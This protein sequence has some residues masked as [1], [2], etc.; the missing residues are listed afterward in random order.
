MGIAKR[1][2]REAHSDIRKNLLNE[3]VATLRRA[4]DLESETIGL[5][6]PVAAGT[7]IQI[8]KYHYEMREYDSAVL[9]IRQAITIYRNAL[10]GNHPQVGKSTLLLASIFDRHGLHISPQGT[11]KDDSELELYVDALEPL[12]AT[13]GEVH[14]EIG[15]LYAKIGYLYGKKGDLS[16]SLLAYKASLKSHGEPSSNKDNLEVMSIWVRITENLTGLKLWDEVLVAGRRALYLLRC[17]RNALFAMGSAS[18]SSSANTTSQ[19]RG[20]TTKKSQIRITSD[21]YYTSLFSTLQSLGHAHTSLSNYALAR[22]ACSESLQL[23][24]EMA[25]STSKAHSENEALAISVTRVIRALKRLGKAYLLEKHY[26]PA[27]ECFL[28]SLELLRS[29]K[30]MESTLDCASVLGSLGFLYLKLKKYAESSNFLR[31]CLRLYHENGE[32]QE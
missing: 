26:A 20:T 16:L 27:L 32:F 22:D 24:W 31:E 17:S 21:T 12:K 4:L 13:L 5:T 9:E 18:A 10:G 8:G 7:L 1:L 25:L 14:A 30:E 2:E 19:P 23:A 11:C 15:F 6:H 28:P 29:S 3:V